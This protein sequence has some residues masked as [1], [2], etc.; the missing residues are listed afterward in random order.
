MAKKAMKEE[1]ENRNSSTQSKYRG[2][3]K[4]K[5]GKWVSEIRLPHS[6]ERIWLGSYDTPEK[7]ARA[8][9]AAQF[10]LRGC[11]SDFNFPDNPP[12]ISGGRS[13]TA[14]EIREAAVRFA[15]AQDDTISVRG[16]E[17]GLSE[18]RPESPSTSVVSEVATSSATTLDCDMSFFLDMIPTDF[19]MFPGFDDFSDGF[20]G[21]RFTEI[22]PIEDYGGEEI[23][24]GS[25]FLWDF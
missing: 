1:E 16:E 24:D 22:S 20:S 5:W 21:D 6:R 2:V 4:R 17:S 15:N 11:D 3:R 14:P 9:D 8:F 23:F 12:S 7:A 25:L 13:L 18:I 10:C 19:E